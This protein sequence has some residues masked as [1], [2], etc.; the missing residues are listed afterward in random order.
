MQVKRLQ[1]HN[2]TLKAIWK[3]IIVLK[4]N[5]IFLY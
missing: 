3:W 4:V 5:Y 2:I 1:R